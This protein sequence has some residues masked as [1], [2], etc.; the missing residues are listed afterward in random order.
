MVG[1]GAQPIPKLSGR[2][3]SSRVIQLAR[4][5][6]AERPD[7]FHVHLPLPEKCKTA[8]LAAILA[9][10]PAI[11]AT[12]QLFQCTPSRRSLL[13]LRI[14]G[15]QIHR[16]IAVSNDLSSH[17]TQDLGIPRRKVALIHDGVPTPETKLDR[18]PGPLTIGSDGTR[19]TVLTCA[20]LHEQKGLIHL[21]EAASLVSEAVFVVAGDGPQR[22]ELKA[23]ASSLGV[24]KQASP[25][26]GTSRRRSNVARQCDMLVL[27]SLFEGL[28]LA[29]LEAM[30]AGEPVI[31][32]F[33][34]GVVEAI[35]NG[36]TGLLVP[37]AKPELLAN[38]IRTL[39]DSPALSAQLGTAAKAHVMR[40]FSADVMVKRVA[41]IYEELCRDR[42]YT[43]TR[44]RSASK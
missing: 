18:E 43:S 8:L 34:G 42:N 16:Y 23:Y 7:I 37:P 33:V 14:L 29:L 1:V 17:L 40:E 20:R 26:F 15:T 32:S 25:L 36:K 9:R 35:I 19:A 2:S 3:L 44:D 13:Y 27:P 28:L 12:E 39:I 24:N 22:A 38:A 41:R 31:A 6:R 30:S 4:R 11:I 10:V 5:L 21:L